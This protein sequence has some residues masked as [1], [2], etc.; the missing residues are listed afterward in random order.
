MNCE[1]ARLLIEQNDPSIDEH[2][3]ACPACV[4]AA[5]LPYYEAPPA[6]EQKIRRS[7][8]AET[9]S[10][11]YWRWA[12]IAASLLLIASLAANFAQLSSRV[13]EQRQIASAVLSDH[14]RSLN[15]THLLDVL[16]SDRH[17]VKPWFDGKIDFAPPVE[18]IPGFPLIGGRLE[19][20]ES[21]PA[22][23]L[24]YGR[25]KHIINLF[26]WLQSAPAAGTAGNLNGYN[27]QSWSATGMT[28]WAGN[29]LFGLKITPE[30]R[31][32][33]F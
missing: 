15:G 7:L 11:A 10:P 6:L 12:A 27:F 16:S 30:D 23:A 25:N 8:H 13:P 14:L 21:R 1:T 28:F 24:I 19:Y 22:A 9:A 32:A 2:R 31:S 20:L 26:I 18:N 5:H 3:R 4:I 17:T 29:C 33:A